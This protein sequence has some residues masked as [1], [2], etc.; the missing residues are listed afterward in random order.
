MWESGDTVIWSLSRLRLK[1]GR[2]NRRSRDS[3]FRMG[4]ATP[5]GGAKVWLRVGSGDGR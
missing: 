5:G 3:P 4:G 1:D 2:P